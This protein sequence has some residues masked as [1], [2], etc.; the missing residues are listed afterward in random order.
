MKRKYDL[1]S[2]I[3]KRN[4]F[5]FIFVAMLFYFIALITPIF[6]DDATRTIM[7]EKLSFTEMAGLSWQSSMGVSMRIVS[8]FIVD[9]LIWM[10]NGYFIWQI[11]NSIMIYALLWTTSYIFIHDKRMNLLLAFLFCLYPYLDMMTAGAV[12]TSVT[13]LWNLT[14]G[15]GVIAFLKKILNSK[16]IS[17]KDVIFLDLLTFV[18]TGHEQMLVVLLV[19]FIITIIFLLQK[20]RKKTLVFISALGISIINVKLLLFMPANY[21]RYI[22]EHHWFPDYEMQSF[23]NKIEMALTSSLHRILFTNGIFMVLMLIL[24]FYIYKKYQDNYRWVYI[25]AFGLVITMA[26]YLP[27]EGVLERIVNLLTMQQGQYGTI[28]VTNYVIVSPYAAIVIQLIVASSCMIAI[29]M[30]CN[31]FFELLLYEGI[32]IIGLGTRMVMGFSPTIWASDDR[33]YLFCWF[34]L[35]VETVLIADSKRYLIDKICI[36]KNKTCEKYMS[37]IVYFLIVCASISNALDVF[38]YRGVY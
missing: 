30:L 5:V 34:A 10:Q 7:Y 21:N 25:S 12:S 3:M 18:A 1:L 27:K 35:I 9:T 20:D 24:T 15:M 26:A 13:Y 31:N 16:K 17:A 4:D 37:D 38:L 33:T 32:I 2:K 28:D 19:V 14:A 36:L 29:G 23:I 11:L 22:S 6:G 8:N